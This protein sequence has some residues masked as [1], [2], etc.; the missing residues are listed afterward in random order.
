MQVIFMR[1]KEAF[2]QSL[3]KRLNIA[4]DKK[5]SDFKWII[6]VLAELPKKA[7]NSVM[8]LTT[9]Q[10]EHF[11]LSVKQNEGYCMARLPAMSA[12]NLLL[13]CNLMLERLRSVP[14]STSI[15]TPP[16]DSQRE[17]LDISTAVNPNNVA[18]GLLTSVISSLNALVP[19]SPRGKSNERIIVCR[20]A[21][22]SAPWS[23]IPYSVRPDR[24][25]IPTTKYCSQPNVSDEIII[26]TEDGADTQ[27]ASVSLNSPSTYSN[28]GL[29]PSL[30]TANIVASDETL[31]S[32]EPTL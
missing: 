32:S 14:S 1:P 13:N 4:G 12:K 24:P 29:L 15:R 17:T 21:T 28:S 11:C 22:C 25:S 5:G 26:L 27:P 19:K 9:S 16:L 7:T 18:S 23:P 30:N 8:H 31:S 3:L 10:F 2:K 6:L 20:K